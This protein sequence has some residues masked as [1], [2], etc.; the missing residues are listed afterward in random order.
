MIHLCSQQDAEEELS[1]EDRRALQLIFTGLTAV[2][3]SEYFEN[4]LGALEDQVWARRLERIVAM[5]ELPSYYQGWLENRPALTEQFVAAVESARAA[6][7]RTRG[8]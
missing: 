7:S 6:E 1:T 2:W 8:S 3:E 4:R 5:L